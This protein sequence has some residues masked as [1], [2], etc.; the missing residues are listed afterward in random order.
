[1]FFVFLLVYTVCKLLRK[2]QNLQTTISESQEE[3]LVKKDEADCERGKVYQGTESTFLFI[4]CVTSR[5]Q[6]PGLIE[7]Q[8]HYGNNGSVLGL[9]HV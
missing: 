2:K 1:M 6:R 5:F 8:H 9:R 3:G 4:R 7:L